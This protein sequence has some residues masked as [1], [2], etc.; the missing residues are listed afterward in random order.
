M[1]FN[2]RLLHGAASGY[3]AGATLPPISQVNAFAYASAEEHEQVFHHRKAGFAYSRIGNPTVA[4]YERRM[5]ELEGGNGALAT[6]SGMAAVALSLLNILGSGDEIVAGSG[7]YGGTFDLFEDLRL[8]GI[9]VT[10]V[11]HVCVEE[12]R[13]VVTERTKVIYCELIGNPGLD[14]VD[15]GSVAAFAHA[16]GIPL[17]VDNTTATPFLANPLSLGADI[18]VHSGSKYIN[19]GGNAISGVIVDGGRFDWDF[20]RFPALRRFRQYGKQ[21]YLVRLRTDLWEN[22]GA[23][24][25]PLNAF[26]N[27]A[28]METLGIRMERICDNADRLARALVEME[29]IRDVNYPTLSGNPYAGLVREEL[30]GLGGGI[31]TF[32]AGSKERAYRILNALEYVKIVSNIGDVRTLA[33]HPA[34]TICKNNTEERR[35]A[36]GVHEDTVRVS[37]GIEDIGD[38]THD[39][40]QAIARANA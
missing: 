21:A 4:A 27:V 37:V 28:G 29:G 15:V 7:L 23:C 35:L 26:L 25:S 9:N 22:M 3:F 5:N 2:T 11:R 10:F 8:F 24:L 16:R 20:D 30:H 13:D 33:V 36:A 19:G 1:H 18:V 6:A 40:T 32:R 39:F 34:S 38:L 14:V 12:L 31:L 17:I